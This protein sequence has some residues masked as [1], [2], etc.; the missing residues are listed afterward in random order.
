MSALRHDRTHAVQQESY[1]IT[2]SAIASSVVVRMSRPQQSRVWT[3][4]RRRQ[5]LD[6][7][8]HDKRSELRGK[9]FHEVLVGETHKSTG[10]RRLTDRVARRNCVESGKPNNLAAPAVEKRTSAHKQGTST[11]LGHG[12]KG[13]IDFLSAARFDNNDFL[14]DAANCRLYF[15]GLNLKS[16]RVWVLENGDD[17]GLRAIENARLLN[18]LRQSLQQQTATADVLKVI[19]RSTFDLQTVL[20]TLAQ[21][22]AELCRADRSGIRLAKDGLYYNV[23]SHGYSPEHK[24]RMERESFKVD[25]SSVVGRVILD[26]KSIHLIDVGRLMLP[27]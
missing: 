12:R 24:A 11:G 23:A 3:P 4:R 15:A 9:T 1:W 14:S 7:L 10:S 6:L 2:S 20:D 13:R 18:E 16:R 17:L 25:R 21:S 26:R 19:S 8:C 22:A 5:Q 27:R